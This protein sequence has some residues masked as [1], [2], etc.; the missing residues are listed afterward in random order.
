MLRLPE[1][2]PTAS[3]GGHSS[4]YDSD[5]SVL[6]GYPAPPVYTGGASGYDSEASTVRGMSPPRGGSPRG[7][8][9]YPA[10]YDSDAS[11]FSF[12]GPS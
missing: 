6:G 3:V 12:A 8:A 7:H 9:R 1:G 2:P 11:T 4:G 10:N 5:V